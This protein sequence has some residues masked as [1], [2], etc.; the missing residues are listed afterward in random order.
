M[1]Q[2]RNIPAAATVEDVQ[3]AIEE[4]GLAV[5]SV[6]FEENEKP[7]SETQ[8]ALVRFPPLPLPWKLS[9]EEL[10]QPVLVELEHPEPAKQ[11][12]EAAAG[13]QEDQHGGQEQKKEEGAEKKE[14]GGEQKDGAAVP[15]VEED[16]KKEVLPATSP[17]K[18]I[19]VQPAKPLPDGRKEGDVYTYAHFVA[20]RLMQRRLAVGE[21]V[22]M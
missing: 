10:A 12:E 14:E 20:T 21:K 15:T 4:H 16:M 17:A 9:E 8:V 11:P 7:D 22:S 5:K 13:K 19:V 1:L 6:V 3:T 18:P 2:V